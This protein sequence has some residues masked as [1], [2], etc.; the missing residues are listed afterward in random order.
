MQ[1]D[2]R[3]AA[4]AF[5]QDRVLAGLANSSVDEYESRLRVFLRWC[6]SHAV[7]RPADLTDLHC[8]H[9]LQDRHR[10]CSQNTVC[11]DRSIL[12]LFLVWLVNRESSSVDPAKLPSIPPPKDDEVRRLF[13]TRRQCAKLF[14]RLRTEYRR[15]RDN[16]HSGLMQLRAL[17]VGSLLFGAGMRISEVAAVEVKHIDL[18]G[19]ETGRR[20]C[21]TE[22]AG[23]NVFAAKQQAGHLRLETTMRYVAESRDVLHN[24]VG[25]VEFWH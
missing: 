12:R 19:H 14:D 2:L 16:R 17:A 24:V 21:I 1:Y 8:R 11:H 5:I 18:T 7:T 4:A 3:A 10:Q 13:L 9:Y 25:R 23:V 15:A 6:D 20:Y 22:L